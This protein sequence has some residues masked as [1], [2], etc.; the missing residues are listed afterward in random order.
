MIPERTGCRVARAAVVRL[1]GEQCRLVLRP[2]AAAIAPPRE[3]TVGALLPALADDIADAGRE[4]RTARSIHDDVANRE[5]TALRLATRFVIDGQGKAAY[6][7]A[8]VGIGRRRPRRHRSREQ[9]RDSRAGD[10][11]TCKVSRD[12]HSTPFRVGARRQADL[13]PVIPTHSGEEGCDRGDQ[14]EREKEEEQYFRDAGRRRCGVTESQ[15]TRDDRY[16]QEQECPDEHADSSASR[17]GTADVDIRCIRP[18][19]CLLSDGGI[20][21]APRSTH[22]LGP[23]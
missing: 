3:L 22:R 9:R 4:E 12:H 6:F 19:G 20:D 7:P 13:P 23:G 8:I 2:V 15:K 11:Q 21:R 16:D 5:L 10:K 18:T 14:E 17:A 1:F